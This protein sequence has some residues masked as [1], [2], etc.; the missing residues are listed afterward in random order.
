MG[1]RYT[2]IMKHLVV[3]SLTLALIGFGALVYFHGTSSAQACDHSSS[4]KGNGGELLKQ[5][6]AATRT[7][8]SGRVVSHVTHQQ[9]SERYRATTFVTRSDMQSNDE[10]S[11]G[12]QT[13]YDGKTAEVYLE[14][15]NDGRAFKR[16]ADGSWAEKRRGDTTVDLSDYEY[17]V[18]RWNCDPTSVALVNESDTTLEFRIVYESLTDAA[19]NMTTVMTVDKVDMRPTRKV[20]TWQETFLYKRVRVFEDIERICE[21]SEYNLPIT[22]PADI[23]SPRT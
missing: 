12:T 20:S 22:F 15:G 8:T 23:P 4:P 1:Q 5:V 13:D 14:R 19:T 3:A 9:T 17:E 10:A 21:F 7:I 2:S 6:D 11:F 16:A 18:P